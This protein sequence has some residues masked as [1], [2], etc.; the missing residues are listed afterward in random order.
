[1]T[2]IA[3]FAHFFPVPQ[4]T[5]KRYNH[6]LRKWIRAKLTRSKRGG[7]VQRFVVLCWRR[8]GSNWLC[9]MLYLH[10][11][12]FMHNELFNEN[13]IHTYYD[14]TLS[15]WSYISRDVLPSKF[16]E[17]SFEAY[18]KIPSKE[19]T[20]RAIGF[21]SFPEHYFDSE[22][23]HSLL[24]ETFD[25]FMGDFDVKKVILYRENVFAVFISMV[26]SFRSGH[27]LTKNYDD[28][29][30][31]VSLRDLQSFVDRYQFHYNKY[32]EMSRGQ[33]PYLISYEEL[34][35]DQ[36]DSVMAGLFAF[37]G[38]DASI[39]PKALPETIP[40]SAAPL[41]E[42]VVNYAE[43]EF[44]Y[45]HT[46]YAKYLPLVH[47]THNVTTKNKGDVA[48]SDGHSWGLLIPICSFSTSLEE[49][50]CQLTALRES[51]LATTS[52]TDRA[53]ISCIF[54]IDT[55]D[56]V[57]DTEEGKD[58][59]F[60]LFD[61]FTVTVE[62]LSNVHGK[63]CKIWNVLANTAYA[64]H[65]EFM[66]LIGDDVRFDTSNWKVEIEKC[67]YDISNE[68]GLPLGVG[69][70]AFNDNAFLGFPTFPV[71]HRSHMTVFDR[72]LPFQFINQ[73]GDPYLFELYRRF[74]CARFADGVYLTNTLGGKLSSTRYVKRHI[75]WNNHILSGGIQTLE[76]KLGR[77]SFLSLDVVVPSYRCD[78][79]ALVAISSL[80]A[81][82]EDVNISFFLIVDNPTAPTIKDI[83]ALECNTCNYNVKVIQH[84]GNF[85]A[86]AARNTGLDYS[87]ADFVLLLDD[88]VTPDK[89]ILDAYIGAIMRYPDARV[90]VGATHFP[91]PMSILTHAYFTSD[92][93]GSFTMAEKRRD[94]PWGVTAN[95]CVRGRTSKARFHLDYPKTGGGEDIDYCIRSTKSFPNCMVAV[96][97]ALARHPWW[98]GGGIRSLVHIKGWA[99][100]E[101]QLLSAKVMDDYVY[102]AGPNGV[103]MALILPILTLWLALCGFEFHWLRLALV[104][105]LVLILEACWH[106]SHVRG[107]LHVSIRDSVV[108]ST[109]IPVVAALVIMFQETARLIAH[110]RAH[111]FK[112]LFWRFDWVCGK[113]PAYVRK[114]IHFTM[115]RC[116]VYFMIYIFIVYF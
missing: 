91:T 8:T 63:I 102:F 51:L 95:I 115:I 98:G 64:K 92:L 72:M 40:Q 36:H 44:A 93:I 2:G 20:T 108:M 23:P 35:S 112:N 56:K 30:V 52:P 41:S 71:L 76:A 18:K 32:K 17:E 110:L 16:L 45:R 46:I 113:N 22:M 103:E 114:Q 38:V 73:G 47:T 25:S 43:L 94:P 13:S 59:L 49:C 90:L 74:G 5:W 3:D 1:M 28:I 77:K 34:C 15:S 53:K 42:V 27:Y 75:R 89:H 60:S 105:H 80:R 19:S 10:P 50:R 106:L 33:R 6:Q 78:V 11:E 84:S 57:Y 104:E 39:Y 116:S 7:D 87:N 109:L 68:S 86:S 85:G 107:R 9:G 111:N 48:Y 97:G 55:G 21:K 69:C 14:S 54:G 70:V 12:I 31:T 62:I 67:F 26:R 88:D 66:V 83:L 81:S 24:H 82:V 58:L 4:R 65:L 99:T 29:K 61:E 101:S 79:D 37:L 100:G 96:P